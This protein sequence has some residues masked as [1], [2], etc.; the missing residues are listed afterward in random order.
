MHVAI[1][2]E[3]G[4]I[5]GGEN[6]LLAVLDH[7]PDDVRITV[8]APAEGRFAEAL[9]TRQLTHVP[10]SLLDENS[11]R[12]PPFEAA[13]RLMPVIEWLKPD[14][15]HGNS[16]STGR[17][18]GLLSQQMG[19]LCTAHLRD[20]IGLSKT[21]IHH[22]NSNR[23]LVAVSRATRDFHLQQGLDPDRVEVLYN[24]VDCE[25]FQPRPRDG[26]LRRE[27]SLP[28]DSLIALTIGQIGMRK[29]LDVLVDAVTINKDQ[30]PE[31]HYVIVGE[32]YS[33]KLESIEYEQRLHRQIE[34]H[35]LTRHFHWLGYRDDIPE[36]LNECD[37]LIHPAR[38]EPLGRVIL[39][40]AASGVSLI[41]TTAGGT[42]EILDHTL[43]GI[44]VTPGSVEHLT[45]ALKYLPDRSGSRSTFEQE[46]RKLACERF[47]IRDRAADLFAFWRSV[48]S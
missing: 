47:D 28:E 1:L 44:L 27:R 6:S 8:L 33:S 3:Y 2:C 32:R 25:R 30:L 35:G 20:I 41:A 23:K 7:C 9:A 16:L 22:L 18:T 15:L 4:S 17:I 45:S 38:Q 37:L 24:G 42:K 43:A 11:H 26:R 13:N 48:A 46:A 40:A 14:L 12:L 36:L 5:N 31:I 39:E 34:E 10:F 19:Q 21:A 29:G